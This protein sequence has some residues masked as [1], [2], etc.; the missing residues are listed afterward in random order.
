MKSFV[1]KLIP[2]FVKRL[3][4]LGWALL[5]LGIYGRPSKKI[6][7]IGITG[8]DGK[9][10]T[11]TFLHKIIK[12]SGKKV[13]MINGLKFALPSKEWKNHSDNSTPGRFVIRKFLKRAIAE[14]CEFVILEVTSWGIE[15]YRVMGIAFDIAVITNFTYEHLDLHGSMERYRKMKGKL[16]EMLKS[17]PKPNQK[18]VSIVNLD[19]DEYQFFKQFPADEHISYSRREKSDIYATDIKEKNH[20]EFNLHINNEPE[21]VALTMRGEFNVSNAL[22]AASA[23]YALGLSAEVIVKGLESVKEVP[24]RMEFVKMGQPF[25]V[26][27]DFAHTPNGF[28]SLFEATRKLVGEN[29][30]IIGVYG[31]TGD[32]DPGRRPMVGKIAGELIDYSFLTTED[33]HTEDPVEIAKQVEVGLKEAGAK[34]GIDYSFIKDRAEAIKAACEKAEAGDAVLLCSMG[35]YDVMYVGEGKIPWS[36]R[37][38]ARDALISLGYKAN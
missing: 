10:T 11:S 18:K 15:Q 22:A 26:I 35:D 29:H 9:T 2:P 24:G 3:Y 27:V 17:A 1:K 8:T 14:D 6:I 5:S 19:A 13:A 7:V 36:D 34:Q 33:P 38:A 37:G 23:A 31:A 32:R 20:L 25:H 16:F 12:Q 30:K 28:R 4:H 21:L